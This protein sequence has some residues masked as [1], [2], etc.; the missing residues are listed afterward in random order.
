M[1]HKSL[2][3]LLK[4]FFKDTMIH[5]PT[6][7]YV[8]LGPFCWLAKF[9]WGP[10]N[11]FHFTNIFFDCQK[12]YLCENCARGLHI[13][14]WGD[15]T[16]LTK[17]ALSANIIPMHHSFVEYDLKTFVSVNKMS[18]RVECY[19]YISHFLWVNKNKKVKNSTFTYHNT[20]QYIV[21]KS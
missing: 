17:E 6:P 3:S 1:I 10:K 2:P 15:L 9:S 7:N 13:I 11:W 14:I 16:S 8:R 18:L 21:H 4:F 19:N 20:I 12:V 5:L